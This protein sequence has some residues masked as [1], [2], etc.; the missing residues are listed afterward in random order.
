MSRFLR[1][2]S[3]AAVLPRSTLSVQSYDLTLLAC[4]GV[5][6]MLAVLPIWRQAGKPTRLPT[7][8]DDLPLL[9]LDERFRLNPSQQKVVTV[10]SM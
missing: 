5:A 10:L 2:V 1:R 6:I 9:G 8:F 4:N 3:I 7:L